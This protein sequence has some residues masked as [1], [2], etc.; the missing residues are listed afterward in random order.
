MNRSL[1]VIAM[2]LLPT[3]GCSKR[4]D[5]PPAANNIPPIAIPHDDDRAELERE[6]IE[7]ILANLTHED[8]TKRRDAAKKFPFRVP[9]EYRPAIPDLIIA[10]NSNHDSLTLAAT[11]A[12]SGLADR[13]NGDNLRLPELADAIQPLS[14]I[15]D[16]T[17]PEETRRWA[18]IAIADIA[19]N[20]GA[21][22]IKLVV[23][24]LTDAAADESYDVSRFAMDGLGKF[25]V[26]AQDSIPVVI[27]QLKNGDLRAAIAAETLADI[28][29]EPER[30]VAELIATLPKS[31]E[32]HV[33]EQI[34]DAL[35]RFGAHSSD[36]VP[37]L[38][39]LLNGDSE[40]LKRTVAFALGQ[41]GSHSELAIPSLATEFEN[42]RGES[43]GYDVKIAT[44]AALVAIGEK[45]E[46]RAS[47]IVDGLT[48]FRIY[49]DGWL[50]TNPSELLRLLSKSPTVT[51]L[52]LQASN[53]DDDQ[54]FHLASMAQ[55]E[56]LVLPER[57]SDDGIQHISGL[58]N[59]RVLTQSRTSMESHN[60]KPITDAGLSSL[61][62]LTKL[63]ILSLA[64]ADISDG[65][66]VH[67]KAF[68]LLE[69]LHLGS[70]TVT[71]KG[72]AHLSSLNNLKELS[73]RATNVGDA[74]VA[75]IVKNHRDLERLNLCHTSIT[76]KC[77]SDLSKLT[78]LRWL[79]IYETPLNGRYPS[80][81]NATVKLEQMLPNCDIMWID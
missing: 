26:Q 19:T 44:L 12:L 21:D 31:Q 51:R 49:G 64:F 68:P 80:K 60:A 58:S 56:E 61:N 71:D 33:T 54:L 73:L 14:G 17:A 15:I 45:G 42:S 72:M 25:G 6:E 39:P 46:K 20:L 63:Q 81:S 38:I 55:L 34:V 35:A 70:D 37:L 28:G 3:V 76:A 75:I 18:T 23:P 78:K 47:Q 16:S 62:R 43:I 24:T 77:I 32:G 13:K 52:D 40:H 74:G 59:L 4:Q 22:A 29:C 2:C 1:V 36:A 11:T 8:W 10:L 65:G 50:L 69:T 79:G 48:E 7:A 9:I 27:A 53:L 67:I 30:C 5:A 41:I 66:L 57:T